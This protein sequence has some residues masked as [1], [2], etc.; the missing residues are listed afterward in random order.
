MLPVSE[1][2]ELGSSNQEASPS[3]VKN[4]GVVFVPYS[5]MEV[6]P[7][8]FSS[9]VD[10]GPWVSFV[11]TDDFSVTLKKNCFKDWCLMNSQPN[12]LFLTYLNSMK[13]VHI[14]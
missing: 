7:Y 13:Y 1:E 11:T 5:H 2:T 6:H 4:T 9:G 14:I 12:F 3:A 10:R 8:S